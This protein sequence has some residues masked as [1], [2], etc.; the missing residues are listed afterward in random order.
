MKPDVKCEHAQ[1]H[2]RP[3]EVVL[4]GQKVKR[5]VL[6]VLASI[7]SLLMSGLAL[8]F[9]IKPTLIPGNM[10]Y[11]QRALAG[12]VEAQMFLGD[13][14]YQIGDVQKSVYYYSMVLK[15]PKLETQDEKR[16]LC[17][18][19]N[20]LGFL[21]S[22]N[23]DG[24]YHNIIADQCFMRGLQEMAS[25]EDLQ[26]LF[27]DYLGFNFLSRLVRTDPYNFI[28]VIERDYPFLMSIETPFKTLGVYKEDNAGK[29]LYDNDPRFR[30]LFDYGIVVGSSTEEA[31][32]FLQGG[33]YLVGSTEDDF[34]KIL[35][36]LTFE[37][38]KEKYQ[39]PRELI[40]R[41]YTVKGNEEFLAD[42][43]NSIEKGDKLILISGYYS[44][45]YAIYRQSPVPCQYYS[46]IAFINSK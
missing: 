12:D 5:N 42:S 20:N 46:Y 38:Y 6:G 21:Y 25:N 24:R 23:F 3:V 2:G 43:N 1:E 32:R 4:V 19:N 18:A 27:W 30:L 17:I 36:C 39:D 22:T 8:L 9:S 44:S 11:E 15:Q 28:D 7:I 33:Y 41:V 13:Y 16:Y 35:D 37:E 31:Y 26:R 14:C 40:E 45:W 29:E 34:E 10:N